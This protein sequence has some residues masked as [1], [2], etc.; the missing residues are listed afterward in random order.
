[1]SFKLCLNMVSVSVLHK[2][3]RHCNLM[4]N[5]GMSDLEFDKRSL[6]DYATMPNILTICIM[7]LPEKWTILF[8]LFYFLN[9]MYRLSRTIIYYETCFII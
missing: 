3:R 7:S 2:F 1:M 9:L 8:H 6:T 4:Y 5:T